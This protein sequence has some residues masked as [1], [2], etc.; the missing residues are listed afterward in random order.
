MQ[1]HCKR[2]ISIVPKQMKLLNVLTSST[3][4]VS[5]KRPDENDMGYFC[6]IV[7]DLFDKNDLEILRYFL[8]WVIIQA[9][10]VE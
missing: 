1:E 4:P 7:P 6:S 9:R 3:G 5:P 10:A 8:F 2:I